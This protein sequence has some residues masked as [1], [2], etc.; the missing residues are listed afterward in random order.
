MEA[1]YEN[2]FGYENLFYGKQ[3]EAKLVEHLNN[4][5]FAGFVVKSASGIRFVLPLPFGCSLVFEV[6]PMALTGS[7]T[8][9]TP[10]GSKVIASFVN[11]HATADL[12][13]F[14]FGIV[15]EA[16]LTSHSL[17]VKGTI[18]YFFGSKS[19]EHTWNW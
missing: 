4:H 14:G 19:F 6:D 7:I 9:N 2:G 12:S 15:L 10:V 17:T 5:V 3:D 18:K 1:K 8:L 13:I 16:I 11:G